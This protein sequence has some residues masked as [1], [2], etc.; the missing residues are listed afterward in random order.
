M[1]PCKVIP[2]EFLVPTFGLAIRLLQDLNS[3]VG[4]DFTKR[5]VKGF[6]VCGCAEFSAGWAAQFSLL[7]AGQAVPPWKRDLVMSPPGHLHRE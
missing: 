2:W 7:V 1:L 4:K 6:L 3:L 5:I